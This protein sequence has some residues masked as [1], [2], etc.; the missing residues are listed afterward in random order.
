MR[1]ETVRLDDGTSI[2]LARVPDLDDETWSQVKTYLEGNAVMAKKLQTLAKDPD[3][4]R[5][6]MQ[7]HAIAEHYNSKLAAGSTL[8]Q[9]RVK[10]L[11]N[12]P[13][14]KEVFEDIR[15]S[16]LDS[17]LKYQQDE[18][19]MLKLSQ[20]M[21][22]MPAELRPVLKDLDETPFTFHEAC[23]KGDLKAVQAW[24]E[25]K[26]NAL[27]AQDH[28]RITPLG[29]AIGANK[30][31]VVKL[32]LEKRAN[33]YAVDASGNSGLHYAAGYGRKELVEHLLQLGLSPQQMNA[34]NQTPIAVAAMNKHTA[35]WE[36]LQ[37]GCMVSF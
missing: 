4:M 21:G 22:G 16:G 27:D 2:E 25:K 6:W 28:R 7:T 24:M 34:K 31:A 29:Y 26:N 18:Q 20:K 5:G 8:V 11:E 23:K 17:V 30:I 13:E 10:A 3:A 36:L 15:K 37:A 32:L 35:V 19:L 14:L 9:E 33:P 1:S 12:D